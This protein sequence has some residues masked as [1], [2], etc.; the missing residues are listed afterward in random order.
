MRV[1]LAEDSAP[2]RRLLEAALVDLGHTVVAAADGAAAWEAFEAEPASLLILD[3]HM[4]GLDGLEVC[5]RVRAAAVGADAFILMVTGRD[6]DEDLA[7]ALAAGVD[8]YVMKPVSPAQLRARVVIAERRLELSAARRAA[9]EAAAHNKWLAG[10]GETVRAVQHQINNPLSAAI[11]YLGLTEECDDV[12][13]I[14]DYLER[15]KEQLR[16]ISAL[17]HS[18][19]TMDEPRSVEYRA[20]GA[21]MLDLST[22]DSR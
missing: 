4:P 2:A 5:R 15:V 20:G 22:G 13:E 18:L 21:R 11:A 17:L 9:E 12:A 1:I 7:S 6:A 3:W 19:S 10:I 8:D 14:Q 16:R